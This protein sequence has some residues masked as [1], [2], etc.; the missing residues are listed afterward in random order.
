M[1]EI[2]RGDH[3]P[4]KAKK[5]RLELETAIKERRIKAA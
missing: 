5:L 3:P 2:A 1:T 4:E